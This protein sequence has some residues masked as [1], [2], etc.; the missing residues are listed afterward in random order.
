MRLLISFNFTSLHVRS[1]I[2]SSSFLPPL[3]ILPPN[4][5]ITIAH[6]QQYLLEVFYKLP[7]LLGENI[8][9]VQRQ[10]D[11]PTMFLNL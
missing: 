6:P 11:L 1:Q 3:L 5:K 9:Q 2:S 7:E 8:V 4:T 10:F